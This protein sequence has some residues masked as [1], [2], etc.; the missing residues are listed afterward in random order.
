LNLVRILCVM[1]LLSVYACATTASHDTIQKAGAHYKIGVA[2]LNE[3]KAQQ[4]FVEFQKSYELNPHN[5]EVL[6]AIG[7]IYLMHFEETEKA[8]NFFE[9]A[10]TADPNYSDAYNNL[11]FAYEKLG[12]FDTA[13]SFYRK[14]VS[15]LLYNT[16]E[17][18]YISMGNSYYRLGKYEDAISAY[19]E[20]IK[21]APDLSLPYIRMALC[22]N[23]MG[24][25]G[26]ASTAMTHA[27]ATDP[28]YKGNREKAIED[29]SIRSL[30]ATG[31]E[32]KDLRDY[33]EIIKY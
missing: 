7:Y 4:A 31:D 33:I 20:A 12:R 30:K 25:Y 9:K 2:Y 11:G 1:S 28:V 8:I 3:A 14:A 29:F 17:K 22:Y 32:E 18:S 16:P 23:A 21:R 24:R 13:I 6:N 27:I 19:K 10:T 26:D 5:K 15:N